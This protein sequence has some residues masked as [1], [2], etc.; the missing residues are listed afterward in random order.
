MTA[1][2]FVRTTDDSGKIISQMICSKTKV[3]PLK[4]LTISRLELSGAV[5]LVKL[6]KQV[7]YALHLEDIRL[8]LWCNSSI[9][10]TWINNYP[11]RWKDFVHSRNVA[12]R[13]TR[14]RVP[15]NL[16]P[17]LVIMERYFRGDTHVRDRE[18]FW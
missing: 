17:L 5:L 7:L 3:A 4:R 13:D 18:S 11:S 16:R 8:C 9:T 1:V 12:A 6:V 14:N 10:L 2:V 15:A